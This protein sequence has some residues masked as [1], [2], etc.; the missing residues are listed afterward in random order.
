MT[1]ITLHQTPDWPTVIRQQVRTVGGAV[2]VAALVTGAIM[3]AFCV[4]SII[5]AA[6]AAA[7]H[8]TNGG[9]PL[10]PGFVYPVFV[11]GLLMAAVVWQREE[12]SRRGYHLAMPVSP[13]QHTAIRVLAGWAWLMI[14]VAAVW[15]VICL[16]GAAIASVSGGPFDT[17]EMTAWLWVAPF[18]AATMTYLLASI[19]MI[20]TERPLGWLVGVPVVSVLLFQMPN[21]LGLAGGVELARRLL[22]SPF[23]PTVAIWPVFRTMS[24]TRH[25]WLVDWQ[26]SLL[27][28]MVWTAIGIAGVWLAARKHPRGAK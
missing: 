16:T 26:R 8:P 15:A 21:V 28:T 18:A 12:P 5:S 17:R 27:G 25:M 1:T 13:T 14:G 11:L 6:R 20:A 4:L 24:V 19:A 2:R 9:F 23:S 3:V 22:A 7:V 10:S